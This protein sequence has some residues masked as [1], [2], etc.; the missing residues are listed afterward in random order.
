MNSVVALLALAV[1]LLALLLS[2]V[3][4]RVDSFGL[5]PFTLKLVV[6]GAIA[7]AIIACIY[8]LTGPTV[9]P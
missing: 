3:A 9:V 4:Q 6:H 8:E 2:A 7:L 5:S 1:V